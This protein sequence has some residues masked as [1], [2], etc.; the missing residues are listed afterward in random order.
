[1]SIGHSNWTVEN[2]KVKVSQGQ[3]YFGGRRRHYSWPLWVE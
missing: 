2:Q 3:R 1:M